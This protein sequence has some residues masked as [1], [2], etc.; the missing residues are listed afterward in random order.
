MQRQTSEKKK[1]N[2]LS[3]SLQEQI[4]IAIGWFNSGYI[5]QY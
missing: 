1:T 3:R 5:R 2:V 4:W